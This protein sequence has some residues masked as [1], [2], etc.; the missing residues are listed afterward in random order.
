MAVKLGSL[1][2]D[3]QKEREGDWINIPALPGVKLKSRSFNYPPFKTERE[4]MLQRLGRKYDKDPIPPDVLEVEFGRL[5]AQHLLLDWGG[6]DVPYSADVA[7]QAL[8]DIAHRPLRGHVEYAAARVGKNE[9]EFTE[10]AAKN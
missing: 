3:I 6:F 7:M 2:D 1:K 10:E 9:V 4:L 8:T 5:Y